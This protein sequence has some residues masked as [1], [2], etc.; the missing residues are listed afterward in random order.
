[1]KKI[2]FLVP[3]L[4]LGITLGCGKKKA[5]ETT[6]PPADTTHTEEVKTSAPMKGTVALTQT[7]VEPGEEITVNFTAEGNLGNNAWIGIVPSEIKHGD[8]NENDEHDIAYQYTGDKTSGNLL[9]VAPADSGSYDFR[10]NS[11]DGNGVEIASVTFQVKGAPNT[12]A[13]LTADKKSYAKGEQMVVTFRAPLTWD[14]EAWIAIVPAA[15]KH[16]K[17]EDADKVDIIYEYINKRSKGTL[18]WTAPGEEGKYSIRMFDAY[19]GK[20]VKAVE[21]TVE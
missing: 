16:G 21:F 6:T 15:T 17:A 2:P 5:P 8:E 11:T 3:L 14:K 13:E 1:M 18:K 10:F 12:K 19:G 7:V 20:E 4:V 9:F